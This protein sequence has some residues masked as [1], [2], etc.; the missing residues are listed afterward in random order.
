MNGDDIKGS[1]DVLHEIARQD[2][3]EFSMDLTDY[4]PEDFDERSED[5]KRGFL[6]AV[7][8]M[9]VAGKIIPDQEVN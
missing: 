3:D 5:Y 2:R 6:D 7:C 8:T 1:V 9:M 4:V